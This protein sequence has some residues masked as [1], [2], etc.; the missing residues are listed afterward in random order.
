MMAILHDPHTGASEPY[1]CALNQPLA[2]TLAMC[3][4]ADKLPGEFHPNGFGIAV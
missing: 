4:Q 2:V 1:Q 3:G